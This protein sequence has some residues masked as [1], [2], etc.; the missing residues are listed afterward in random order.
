MD[1]MVLITQQWLNETYGDIAGFD[2]PPEDGRTGWSTVTPLVEALQIELGF[3]D[4][5]TGN[6]GPATLAACPT[7]EYNPDAEPSNFVKILQGGLWCKG[8]GCDG[9]DGIF[10]DLT[11]SGVMQMQVDMGI[12]ND[13]IVTPEFFW[14]LL[15]MNQFVLLTGG[16]EFIRGFQQFFN[17]NYLDYY[18]GEYIPCDGLGG[19]QL[20]EAITLVVQAYEGFS[21]SQATGYFGSTTAANF[22]TLSLNEESTLVYYVQV[23]LALNGYNSGTKS[24]IYNTT[25]EASVKAFQSFMKLD[26]VDGVVDGAMMQNLLISTGDSTRNVYRCDS[27][28]PL[29]QNS[30]NFLKQNGYNYV[31]RYITPGQFTWGNKQLTTN[32]IELILNNG[33]RI[34]P[35]FQRTANTA[36]YFTAE[37]GNEDA[38]LAIQYANALNI[39][40]ATIIYF[41]VDYDYMDGEL[42]S[43]VVPYFKA[44]SGVFNDLDS[45]YRIGIY[46]SRNICTRL[47]PYT[48]TSFVSGLSWGYSGN[49]G[50]KM[51]S[52]WAFNQI[53]T[54]STT[55]SGETVEIDNDAVSG[56]D[57]GFGKDEYENI[58]KNSNVFDQ[59]ESIYNLAYDY[60][61]GD[62]YQ[63]NLLTAMF[64]RH[65]SYN[66]ALWDS[67]AG[68]IDYDFVSFVENNLSNDKLG[69]CYDPRTKI[70]LDID[71]LAA[72]INALF[73]WDGTILNEP[74]NIFATWGGDLVTV[75]GQ[76][77]TTLEFPY[78]TVAERI[79]AL[80]GSGEYSSNFSYS[81][82]MADIDAFNIYYLTNGGTTPIHVAFKNYY[83]NTTGNCS[84]N[85]TIAW[86]NNVY[87]GSLTAALENIEYVMT[88]E[89]LLW[90]TMRDLL[91]DSYFHLNDPEALEYYTI[92]SDVF[93]EYVTNMYNSGK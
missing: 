8:Y 14:A 47:K 48:V 82:Y 13:G 59:I 9:L 65:S 24:F 86:I 41:A 92:A 21:P 81:D 58:D 56:Y 12:D 18:G 77:F 79:E 76:A 20:V 4:S 71:H 33:L 83:T 53:L 62:I 1:Q 60:T 29:T 22:P 38:T 64:I 50:F 54:V 19:R 55:V 66:G 37:Q 32:E 61:N 93:K 10:G 28:R 52:N 27:A 25:I 43:T 75:A 80:I 90:K 78:L 74:K 11:L 39:P 51:P 26:N 72:S 5:F 36:D 2:N 7:L 49:L 17:A 30:I 63:S 35:I 88:T 84:F 89:D 69:N 73:S 70:A 85:R 42:D 68:E 6:F 45:K 87:G 91:N 57:T 31:G 44:I 23:A 16:N 15:T 40:A 46:A 3:E 67:V 34:F